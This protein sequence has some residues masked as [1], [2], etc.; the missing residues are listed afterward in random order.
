MKEYFKFLITRHFL[1]H[2]FLAIGLIIA[3]FF[4]GILLLDPYTHHGISITVPDFRGKTIDEILKTLD[5]AN[6]KYKVRDTVYFD[7]KR[8]GSILE[9]DPLPESHVKEGRVIYLTINGLT[10]PDVKFP[11]NI[12]GGSLRN[13][14]NQLENRGLNSTVIPVSGQH[15]DYVVEARYLGNIAKGGD[16]IPKGSNIDLYVEK[17]SGGNS[18]P[19][20]DFTGKTM[21][22]VLQLIKD[23]ELMQPIVSPHNLENDP[24]AIVD[25]QNPEP[26]STNTISMFQTDP[27]YI[28]LKLKEE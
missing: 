19:I 15:I 2:F 10:P 7:D 22:E 6:L 11:D 18:I 14:K 20:P 3:L 12:E 28:Y 21:Q 5:E 4:L 1:K 16:L 8:K 26:D 24:N 23:G 17:G 9:Q 25:H 13:A 27:I